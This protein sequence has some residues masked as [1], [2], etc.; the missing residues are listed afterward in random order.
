MDSNGGLQ[1]L[2]ETRKKIEVKIPGQNRLTTFS[3]IFLALILALYGGLMLY[4]GMLSSD[5]D[6]IERQLVDIEKGRDKKEEKKML[7]LHNTLSIIRPLLE[8]HVV[9]SEGLTRIQNLVNPQVQFDSLSAKIDREEYI[10][11]AY[12]PNYA[13]I[14]KQIAAFYTDPAI[15][16]VNLGKVT[17]LPAGKLEFNMLLNLDIDQFLRKNLPKKVERN[18]DE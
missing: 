14:A 9:W 12:A 8:S 16:D 18:T 15:V 6:E 11:K 7:D 10:F 17:S 4:Q 3:F 5:L 2:P 13:V 1:L